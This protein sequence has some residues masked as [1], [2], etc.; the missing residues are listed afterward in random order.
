LKED[1]Q[2]SNKNKRTGGRNKMGL[3]EWGSGQKK[4]LLFVDVGGGLREFSIKKVKNEQIDTIMDRPIRK[5]WRRRD[6]ATCSRR[7]AKGSG[8]KKKRS[9]NL[10]GVKRPDM[11]VHILNQIQKKLSKRQGER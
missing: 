1:S 6:E 9:T 4:F 3:S 5:K 11:G 2:V 8:G 10:K 7:K